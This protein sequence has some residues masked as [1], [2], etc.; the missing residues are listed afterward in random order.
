MNIQKTKS[1]IIFPVIF[2]LI[3]L[4]F[5]G[6][7]SGTNAAGGSCYQVYLPVVFGSGL[8]HQGTGGPPG[9]C[10]H[11]NSDVTADFNGD[12]Y[13]D[14]AI[15]SPYESVNFN[16]SD[17]AEAGAVNIIYGTP[18]G[19]SS[20]NNQ[21]WHRGQGDLFRDPEPLDHFGSDLAVGDFD[22]DG[23]DDLAIGVPNSSAGWPLLDDAGV[24]QVLYGSSTG[25]TADRDEVWAQSI[26]G[27]PGLEE[28]GDYFGNAV[29]TGDFNFD[30]YSDLAVGVRGEM[31]SGVNNAG[32]VN[33]I[34]G[35]SSG[36]SSA[37][38]HIIT[39]ELTGS[40]DSPGVSDNFGFDLTTGDFDSDG[41]DDLA[42][43]IPSEDANGV[44]NAGA[45]Q[46][47]YGAGYG[48]V[49]TITGSVESDFWHADS[50]A[51]VDGVADN[52][53]FFGRTVEAADFNNDGF[54]DLAVGIPGET[55]GS[56]AEAIN[57]AGAINIFYG[58]ANG[59]AATAAQPAPIWHQDSPG[60]VDE[61]EIVER[62][63]FSLAA[64]DFDNDGYAD[65][66]VGVPSE[67]DDNHESVGAVHIMNGSAAGITTAS[68]KLITQG[69]PLAAHMDEFG[70]VVSAD[71]YNGDGFFDLSI[72]A[73]H[74]TTFIDDT[75]SITVRYGES[76]GISVSSS[77]QLWHQ[78]SPGILGNLETGERFGSSLN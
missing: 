57:A 13:A 10:G 43:G 25:L 37:N 55:H 44:N 56:G 74:D 7:I 12:G 46:I 28:A 18:T 8:G 23:Y 31:V 11:G 26:T 75:G 14:L 38:S 1:L 58:S 19:L 51:Y 45:V 15:G 60:M 36:L 65:L 66:A 33:V 22:D 69:E 16:G 47:F 6:G 73:P 32:A 54:V 64:G 67:K 76:N 53:D 72:G 2:T 17:I 29:T 5:G 4:L 52:N 39:Q 21:I 63:G 42:V 49:D 50:N 24:V 77:K 3:L 48:L 41:I 20:D 9:S 30:G 68:N 35:T 62:F 70:Y 27:I 34:Y 78:G 71:D 61:P 40:D 59:I